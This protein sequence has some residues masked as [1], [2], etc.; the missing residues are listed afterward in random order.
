MTKDDIFDEVKK[1][2]CSVTGDYIDD[3]IT[4]KMPLK[5]LG[6]DSLDKVEISVDLENEFSIEIPDEDMEKLLTVG[7]I[8][9][10]IEQRI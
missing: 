8:V 2:I 10:F 4:M 7:E 5:Q 9:D 1:C 3:H 6:V